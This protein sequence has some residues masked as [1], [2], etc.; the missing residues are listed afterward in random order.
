M[1]S[2]RSIVERRKRGVAN[3]KQ[4]AGKAQTGG[5]KSQTTAGVA[6]RKQPR[7]KS[8]TTPP[9]GG[10]LETIALQGFLQAPSVQNG[11][12]Y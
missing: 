11:G 9:G 8:Q 2:K 4:N 10:T 7:S 3:R 1:A 12:E 5:G 6:N